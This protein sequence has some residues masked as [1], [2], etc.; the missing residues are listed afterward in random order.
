MHLIEPHLLLQS[1]RLC[2]PVP[3]HRKGTHLYKVRWAGCDEEEDTWEPK[4]AIASELVAAYH[5]DLQTASRTEV[6]SDTG[7]AA[8]ESPPPSPSKR[9]RQPTAATSPSA[10]SPAAKVAH[11]DELEPDIEPEVLD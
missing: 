3:R 9:G 7:M 6:G 8:V 11:V 5:R 1:D 4:S 10:K 2:P